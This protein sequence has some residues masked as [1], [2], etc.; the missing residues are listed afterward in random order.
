MLERHYSELTIDN[1]A[2]MCVFSTDPMAAKKELLAYLTENPN[3]TDKE[4]YRK[5][6]EIVQKYKKPK[7]SQM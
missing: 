1:A 6:H 7:P 3:A 2:G 5:V 4:A